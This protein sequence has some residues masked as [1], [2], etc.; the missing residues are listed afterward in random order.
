MG[1]IARL[2]GAVAKDE[3]D[4]IRLN[5][6]EPW[7][8]SST[9]DV[10]RFLRALPLS[11][12]EGSIAY[13]EG[14][15]E[16]HVA[17]YLRGVSIPAQSRVAIGTIWP[18]PD[19]YH[20]PVTAATCEAF[21][22]F[23]EQRPAGYVCSHCHVYRDG[24]VLLEWHDAF[25]SEPIYLSRTINEDAVARFAQALGSSFATGWTG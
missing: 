12:P 14:T 5:E 10:E 17:E 18:R 22:E 19:S 4:G 20:V 25:T 1:F 3:R 21:A 23:L 7:R 16:P 24:L 8:V 13:F 11:M 2:L 9:K 15:G 6:A